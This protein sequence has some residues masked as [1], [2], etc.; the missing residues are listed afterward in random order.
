[1]DKTKVIYSLL[2]K[3]FKEYNFLF[4]L[5]EDYNE[6]FLCFVYNIVDE[7]LKE[8]NLINISEELMWAHIRYI[9]GNTYKNEIEIFKTKKN[10][11]G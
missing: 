5:T 4:T 1:M 2:N 10:V 7:Y 8:N 3:W 6:Q 9:V 11:D